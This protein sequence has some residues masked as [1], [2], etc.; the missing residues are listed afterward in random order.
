MTET[1]ATL[2]PEGFGTYSVDWKDD[3][4]HFQ[5]TDQTSDYCLVPGF[6]D[7]HCHGA[8][9]VDFMSASRSDFDTLC[10]FL[11]AQGYEAFLPTT[12][13]AS[14]DAVESALDDLP[15]HAMVPGFHL[16][17]PFISP[18]FPGAQP[19]DAIFPA[20]E[21]GRWSRVLQDSRLKVVTMAPEAP[22]GFELTSMLAE[23]GV[24]VSLGHTNATYDE[25]KR[26][27]DLGAKHTT[28]TFNASRP[29]HH[30]E[31]GV[32]GAALTDD[33][34]SCE[35][36]FDNR[37]VHEAVV[38]V[39]LRCKGSDNL[40]A[41]S[42]STAA[43][44]QPD[45]TELT[46]WGHRCIVNEGKVVIAET[47]ALAGSTATLLDCFKNFGRAFGAEVATKVCS[48]NPR[49]ALGLASPPSTWLVFDQSFDLLDIR[50]LPVPC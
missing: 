19:L 25:A 37:H 1:F 12:V 11:A 49:R 15:E 13:T 23:R 14:A 44:G 18:T 17:G 2:G 34:V 4:P 35:V 7:I 5:L 48:I 39:L 36:I 33:R 22:G 8:M 42:D 6:V 28:H 26:A 21:A 46:M 47:G 10:D 32:V 38:D 16:E 43:T 45:G 40:I 27:F 31:P 29:L 20:L 30:R 24:V 41:V 50:R 9:G 3:G